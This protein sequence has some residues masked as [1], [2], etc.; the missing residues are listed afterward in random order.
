MLVLRLLCIQVLLAH[1]F[2]NLVCWMTEEGKN[3]VRSGMILVNREWLFTVY[4]KAKN[5]GTSEKVVG[6]QVQNK[7]CIVK[8]R[9]L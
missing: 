9:H 3:H 6:W 8:L 4:H 7:Q 5:E 2:A 1:S